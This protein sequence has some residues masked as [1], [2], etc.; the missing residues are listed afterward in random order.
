MI[1]RAPHTPPSLPPR[2][3]RTTN[4]R[5]ER[6]PMP[7]DR[8]PWPSAIRRTLRHAPAG[9]GRL[10][11]Q[12]RMQ[13][14][15]VPMRHRVQAAS[16]GWTTMPNCGRDY[17]AGKGV[18]GRCVTGSIQRPRALFGTFSRVRKYS[19][20]HT[21][22]C[23]GKQLLAPSRRTTPS[24]SRKRLPPPSKRE[25]FPSAFPSTQKPPRLLSPWGFPFIP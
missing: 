9:N 4:P 5:T 8:R 11:R 23:K 24:V 7:R 19:L 17:Y 3:H 6:E 20:A 18:R 16:A 12:W 15:E 22:S 25:A 21:L 10:R 14:P 13:Q 2:P 1:A